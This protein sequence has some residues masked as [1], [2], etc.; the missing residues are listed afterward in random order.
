MVALAA[1]LLLEQSPPARRVARFQDSLEVGPGQ[2]VFVL[3]GARVESGRLVVEPGEVILLVRQ[4]D[5]AGL[6]LLAAGDGL[7]RLTGQRA[8]P[9]RPA[10]IKV[11]LE[12]ESLSEL[13]DRR[14]RRE[15]LGRLRFTLDGQGPVAMELSL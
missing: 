11:P 5:P 8:F 7:L 10:G 12:V 14:G 9:L 3:Q 4:R 15:L 2:T 1:A 13:R 6:T